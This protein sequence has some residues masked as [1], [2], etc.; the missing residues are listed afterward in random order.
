MSKRSLKELSDAE[1]FAELQRCVENERGCTV[2]VLLRLAEV[3]RR[4]AAEDTHCGSLFVYCVRELGYSEGAAYR[5]IHA[6]RCARTYPRIYVLL[7]RG[8]ITLTT[9]SILAP[10]LRDENY[11]ALLKQACGMTR[12]EVE[13]LVAKSEPQRQTKES[14]RPLG[15]EAAQ[16]QGSGGEALP[17]ASGPAGPADAAPSGAGPVQPSTSEAAPTPV[18]RRVEFRFSADEAFLLKVRRAHE[19]RWHK[20]PRGRLED[21]LDD[22][23]E[24]LLDRHD[25][26]RRIARRLKKKASLL[27][28]HALAEATVKG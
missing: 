13:R 10:H 19:V 20:Y 25:P 6:A 1:L 8:R 12:Y 4:K 15:I 21:I 22:A 24:A 26:A 3:D 11:R 9:V 17:F 18:V 16:P 23:I 27:A 14:I 28:P 5:R 2:D 7:A